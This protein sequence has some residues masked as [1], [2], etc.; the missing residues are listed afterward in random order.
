M[1]PCGLFQTDLSCDSVTCSCHSVMFMMIVIL[2]NIKF[3]FVNILNFYS[4]L[5]NQNFLLNFCFFR[6]LLVFG[7]YFSEMLTFIKD[8]EDLMTFLRCRRTGGRKGY[9]SKTLRSVSPNFGPAILSLE[10]GCLFIS[11]QSLTQLN[12]T[13]KLTVFK[14]RAWGMYRF[15]VSRKLSSSSHG[16]QPHQQADCKEA[17]DTVSH[18][19]L[20]GRL[21]AHGMDRYTLSWGKS[22]LDSPV[23]NAVVSGD[24]SSWHP[25][26][27]GVPQDS[28]WVQ[29][30]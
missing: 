5:Q 24:I 30:C 15:C 8:T 23:Q 25:V 28:C 14:W 2:K 13:I 20:L 26:N 17:F 16:G 29:F 4:G 27:S 6:F 9:S 22:W 18:N 7:F 11:L 21:A 19:I 1:T 12:A 10:M 3:I